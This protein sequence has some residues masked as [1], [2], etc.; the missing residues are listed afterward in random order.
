MV[1]D[2]DEPFSI[3]ARF[4]NERSAARVALAILWSGLTE[5]NAAFERPQFR[6]A[7]E[8]RPQSIARAVAFLAALPK[9]LRLTGI[10]KRHV[11]GVVVIEAT[12]VQSAGG[13]LGGYLADAVRR[14]GGATALVLSGGRGL[15]VG[16]AALEQ[17]RD[18]YEL[19]VPSAAGGGK[20]DDPST[21]ELGLPA[22]WIDGVAFVCLLGRQMGG[23]STAPLH[24]A[25][26]WMADALEDLSR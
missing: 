12:P 21:R 7:D 23:R 10:T 5:E 2:A 18:D 20:L 15:R 25:D 6:W 16:V 14:G 26:G 3:H 13:G 8:C 19:G 9:P 11:P 17:L 24:R 4:T 22:A 1:T